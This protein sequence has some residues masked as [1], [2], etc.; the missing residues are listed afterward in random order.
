MAMCYWGFG[1]FEFIASSIAMGVHGCLF[2]AMAIK[3]LHLMNYLQLIISPS[4][5]LKPGSV[6]DIEQRKTCSTQVFV[7]HLDLIT[8][9]AVLAGGDQL[10]QIAAS[11][12]STLI[13]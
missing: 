7:R 1:H 10:F 3:M 2:K 11:I 13:L 4:P 8:L 6:T 9:V 5:M 12:N